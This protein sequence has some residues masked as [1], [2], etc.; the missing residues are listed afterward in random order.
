LF[1]RPMPIIWPRNSFTLLEPE[2][3][4]GMD[5]LKIAIED[6]FQGKQH[7]TEAAVRNSGFS[8]AA[9]RIEELEEHINQVFTEM[10]P[11]VHSVESSLT[12]ALETAHRKIGHNV[13]L[14]KSR[15]IKL[16]AP[17]NPSF[18]KEIDSIMSHCYPN[19]NLQE[20]EFSIHP[21]LAR[22]GPSI[23]QLIQRTAAPENFA[24]QALRLNHE[25]ERDSPK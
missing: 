24:H 9:G 8:K 14:L 5:R 17:R 18:P 11:V 7:I 19:R 3:W 16:E 6:C 13:Q 25:N 2:I 22:H 1:H 15:I 21:F 4:E 20:R 23:L 12:Q 10:R